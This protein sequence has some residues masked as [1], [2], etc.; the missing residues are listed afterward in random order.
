VQAALVGQTVSH[1]PQFCSSVCRSTQAVP[2][3]D[4]PAG[5]SQFPA[6]QVAPVAQGTPQAPQFC[7][8][9][10]RFTHAVPQVSGSA[11]GQVQLPVAHTSFVSG[12]AFPHAAASAPQFAGSFWT[13]LQ[14]GFAS[15]QE[16]HPS[17]WQ[18]P[19]AQVPWPQASPHV[20]QWT[21]SLRHAPAECA[22]LPR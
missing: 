7:S 1:V 22:P 13:S 8:S 3:T 12:Q 14:R 6:V 11:T 15:G 5:H 9:V 21:G 4:W 17:H 10:A 2:Q 20:P 19:P 16:T 18:M